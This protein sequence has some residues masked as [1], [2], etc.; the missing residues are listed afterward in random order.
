MYA[1]QL[2]A[3]TL[4]DVP[5]EV[6]EPTQHDSALE[7]RLKEERRSGELRFSIIPHKTNYLLPVTYN[8]APNNSVYNGLDNGTEKLDNTEVKFQLSIKTPV[9][10]DIFGNNGTLYLAYSQLTL[11]QAYNTGYSSPFREI[12]FEPE[13]FLSFLTNFQMWGMTGKAVTVGYNHQSNGRAKPL[14]RGWNRIVANLL[15]S[16]NEQTYISLRPWYRMSGTFGDDENFNTNKYYGCGELFIL[17]KF[18]DHTLTM[19]L[20]N[21]LRATGNK[22]AVQLDW[23]FPLHRNLKGYVQYFNGYGESL[24]DYNHANNRFGL[25]VMLTDLL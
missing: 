6:P 19:M 14:S 20:R 24:V 22:G 1:A 4:S 2:Q 23:S 21:N 15:F 12:N 5:S 18:H 7:Q 8:T 10:E 3:N 17:Q 25:G 11:W 13:I 16:I 9:W